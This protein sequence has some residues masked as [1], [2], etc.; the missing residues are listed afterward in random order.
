[1]NSDGIFLEILVSYG[2]NYKIPNFE[3]IDAE[4]R[5]YICPKYLN[6]NTPKLYQ[7]WLQ[8]IDDS[9]DGEVE[10]KDYHLAEIQ[11]TLSHIEEDDISPQEKARMIEESHIEEMEQRD[12]EIAKNM[13]Q[14]GL[15]I[16]VISKA[17]G[18]DEKI[19]QSLYAEE[20]GG[21]GSNHE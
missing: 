11:K 4:C 20:T 16:H 1:M 18:L 3:I 14:Q 5:I 15:G 6:K 2:T 12:I 19:I 8:L 10:E 13:L 7:E 17:T 21:L 9:L